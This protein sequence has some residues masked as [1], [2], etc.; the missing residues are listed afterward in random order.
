MT[1]QARMAEASIPA[2]RGARRIRTKPVRILE[3]R[4]DLERQNDRIARSSFTNAVKNVF[5]A[6]VG[7][8]NTLKDETAILQILERYLEYHLGKDFVRYK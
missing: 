6:H 1:R 2:I 7:I 8:S 5:R 3:S 4:N